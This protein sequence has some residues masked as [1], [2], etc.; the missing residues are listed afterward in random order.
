MSLNR[1]QL[2]KGTIGLLLFTLPLSKR[3][4]VLLLGVLVLSGLINGVIFSELKSLFKNRIKL[5]FYLLY[6]ITAS[7]LFYSE[8]LYT[9]L[10]SLQ[11]KLSF[12]LIPL[13]LNAS[14][15]DQNDYSRFKSSFVNGS[16]AA[17]LICLGNSMYHYYLSRQ[18][19]H[20]YYTNFSVL[21]HSSY[22][23]MYLTF[24]LCIILLENTN[25]LSLGNSLKILIL[26]L[27]ILLCNSRSGFLVLVIVAVTYQINLI[28]ISRKIKKALISGSVAFI[29]ILISVMIPGLNARIIEGFS[30]VS[31]IFQS[32][33]GESGTAQQRTEIWKNSTSLIEKNPILGVGAG[34]VKYELTK[35]N[36]KNSD[37]K[38]ELTNLNSHNQFLETTLATGIVGLICLL[39]ILATILRNAIHFN[40]L[41]SLLTF[42]I[43]FINFCFESMLETQSGIVF[44]TVFLVLFNSR[45]LKALK[46]S[47]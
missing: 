1:G 44:T 7:S 37:K 8:N 28:F 21:I 9:G 41:Y 10:Y 29:I 46:S 24:A 39:G 16:I 14:L 19:S 17:I 42:I 38:P 34:D 5:L 30:G 40:D 31:G 35:L 11:I 47:S 25:K 4:T 6:I 20:F 36:L 13:A 26:L 33:S 3:L 43:L 22:F 12:L 32:F 27:G 45:D 15:F 18:I 2:Y 23:A